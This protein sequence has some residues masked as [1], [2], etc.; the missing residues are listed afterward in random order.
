MSRE[1]RDLDGQAAGCSR[2]H[3]ERLQRDARAFRR[4]TRFLGFEPRGTAAVELRNCVRC[5]STLT[6]PA[7]AR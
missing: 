4:E 6:S 2:E 3:H 7:S 5:G 1:G